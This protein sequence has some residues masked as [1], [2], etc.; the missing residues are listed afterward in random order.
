MRA[1]ILVVED[2]AAS[3]VTLAYLLKYVG[4]SVTQAPNGETAIDFLETDTFDVIV[5]DIVMDT[6]DGIEVL[7][8][9][10]M[11]PY[12]PEVILLTGHGTLETAIAALRAGA[13]DYLLKPCSDDDLLRSVERAV[14]RHHDEQNLRGAADVIK[15]FYTPGIHSASAASQ[16]PGASSRPLAGQRTTP[17]IQIGELMIGRTR[18]EVLFKGQPLP[19]TPIE[20]ALLRFL[21]ETPGEV[22]SYSDIVQRTHHFAADDAEAQILV[23][24]HVRNLRKKLDPAYL[25]NDRGFGYKLLNP[26]KQAVDT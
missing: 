20:F 9:A 8:T 25:E 16:E 12:R 15:R 3:R 4:Y 2:D 13:Y 5:T 11:Q 21:A 19:L 14:Q 22:R 10:R 7:H 6:V 17:T 24:Q 26:A 18:H 23:K 1:S